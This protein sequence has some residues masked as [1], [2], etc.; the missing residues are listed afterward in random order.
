VNALAPGPILT[1]QLEQAGEQAQ[2]MVAGRLPVG[3]LGRP[4]EVA[5]A[6]VWLS[7]DQARFITGVTLPIDGG[8]LAGMPPYSRTEAK[9]S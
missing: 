3:R 7:S 8:L 4:A 9:D 2:A 1:E 5:D 6:V